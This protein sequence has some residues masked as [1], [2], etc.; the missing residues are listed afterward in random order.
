MRQRRYLRLLLMLTSGLSILLALSWLPFFSQAPAALAH[1]FVIGS[2]PVD[3]STITTAPSMIRIFFNAD[4]S[5]ASTAR[6]YVFAPG[7]PS[8]GSEVDEGHSSIPANNARELDTQLVSPASLPQ[9]SY[10]V[11]WTA[12]ATDDGHATS[13][14]IGFNFGYS[15]TG[16][17]GTS[18]LGPGTSNN[19]PQLNL[20]GALAVMWEWLTM[21]A[22]TFWIGMVMMEG[23]LVLSARSNVDDVEGGVFA[24]LRK[25]GRPLQWLCLA[26]VLVGEIINLVLRGALLTQANLQGGI[27]MATLR[28]L[29]LETSYGH[30]WMARMGLV[31]LALGFL[32]WTTREQNQQNAARF[33][34]GAH[35]RKTGSR[36]SQMRMQ[37]AVELQSEQDQGSNQDETTTGVARWYNI[38]W[39]AL[40]ALMLLTLAFSS[41]TTQLAQAHYS[42]VILDWLSLLAQAAWFGGAAYL[43]F[44]LLP[45]LTTLEPNHHGNF[46]VNLLRYYTPLLLASP[47][48][49]LFSS[50]FLTETTISNAQQWLNDPYGRALLVKL[51]LF[52]LVLIFT[53]YS[54]F[55]LRPAL[56]RQ[57]ALLP[58]V[59]IDLPARRARRSALEQSEGSLKRAM[60]IMSVLGAGVLLC[61]ALMSFFAPPIVFPNITYT[62]NTST[63]APTTTQGV[64]TQQAGDLTVSLEVLP[65]RVGA[66]NIAIVSLKDKGNPVTDAQVQISTNMQVMNMGTVNKDLPPT[67]DNSTY[68]AVFQQGE[69]F[70]MIGAWVISLTIQRPNHAPVQTRFVVTLTS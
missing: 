16:L 34:S 18:I 33:S 5:P 62:N 54:F 31:C 24:S 58:V 26:A 13:G 69:S 23:L 65:G 3:G 14:L 44:V 30:F 67:G 61:A 7:G 4:I 2:D 42:A 70:S 43:G 60:H 55:Y 1:A 32:W 28:Q 37:V 20:Q 10:E 50:L 63:T 66:M 46:L 8:N 53:I 19:L 27:D 15:V 45:L 9:G 64:L 48:L 47:G 29:V 52:A 38:A 40:A 68:V 39:L 11:K 35:A 59:D 36:F 21:L 41:D 6:V 12:V 51:L 57:A 22:L 56:R 25:Q 17:S 49:L